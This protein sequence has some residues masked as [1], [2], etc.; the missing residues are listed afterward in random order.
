MTVQLAGLAIKSHEETSLDAAKTMWDMA[1]GEQGIVAALVGLSEA[2]KL[3][4][5]EI[6][7]FV[8]APVAC[9]NQ[10]PMSAPKVFQICDG[11]FS[12]DRDLADKVVLN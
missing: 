6:G 1:R 2:Y 5:N 10:P 8:G 9:V 7:V 3:R 12:L 4:L 11:I